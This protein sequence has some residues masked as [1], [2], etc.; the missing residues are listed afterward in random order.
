MD[1]RARS[2]LYGFFSRLFVQELDGRTTEL[3]LGPIGT[4]LLPRLHASPDEMAALRDPE[5]RMATFDTDFVHLTVVNVVPYASFYSREDAMVESGNQ[6]PLTEFLHS[7]GLEID[8][9]AARSLAPDHVGIILEAMSSLC[10][11]EAE[12][13][14]RPD[15]DYAAQIRQIQR[16]LLREFMLPW[17]PLYFFAVERCGHTLLYREAARTCM[18]FIASDHESLSEASPA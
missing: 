1:P 10:G 15:P 14:A 17:M 12:A 16:R 5:R 3:V 11:A 9:G 7:Y 13:E 2:D 8:L 4:E 18:E 6:N